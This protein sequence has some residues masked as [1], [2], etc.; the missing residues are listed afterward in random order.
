MKNIIFLVVYLISKKKTVSVS[1]PVCYAATSLTRPTIIYYIYGYSR[2]VFKIT[3][4]FSFIHN[5]MNTHL[6]NVHHN[7]QPESRR[8]SL[9]NASDFSGRRGRSVSRRHTTKF[10]RL[11]SSALYQTYHLHDSW[12]LFIYCFPDN[13]FRWKTNV[14]IYL[15]SISMFE[16]WLGRRRDDIK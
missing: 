7:S 6:I 4:I 14:Y 13:I 8:V 16:L 5:T 12:T 1:Y 3:L 10:T 2:Y 15:R 9:R 11:I